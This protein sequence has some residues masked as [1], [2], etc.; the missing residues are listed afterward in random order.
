MSNEHNDRTD[1]VTSVE[2]ALAQFS[3]RA[4]NVD[5]D[6]LMFLAGAA[7][8]EARSQVSGVRS[9]DVLR[10][11]PSRRR[12]QLVWPAATVA[13]AATSLALAVAL[14]LQPEPRV[15]I[16]YLDRPAAVAAAESPAAAPSFVEIVSPEIPQHVAVPAMVQ[17]TKTPQ[18]ATT[19]HD[20]PDSNYL[21]TREV[22]LRMGLDA[23]GSPRS[24]GGAHSEAA[25][26]FDWLSGLTDASRTE[27]AEAAPGSKM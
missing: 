13:M 14:F 2:R 5:R 27:P 21:R 1:E 19:R 18:T 15:Q 22:A 4:A 26:Y 20:M 8:V 12:F 9:Q 6:R 23:L 25:S 3:P 7:A 17:P 16:V 24:A 11:S 10:D